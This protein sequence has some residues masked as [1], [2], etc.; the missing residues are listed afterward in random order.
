MVSFNL[1]DATLA[2]QRQIKRID[3]L[4]PSVV[5][6]VD[7][8]RAELNEWHSML[9]PFQK[10][11]IATYHDPEDPSTSDSKPKKMVSFASQ[12]TINIIPKEDPY[13]DDAS[14]ADSMDPVQFFFDG[15][16]AKPLEQMR[17]VD[18]SASIEK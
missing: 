16:E 18:L 8:Y 9:K 13:P 2:Q 7:A 5:Q 12:I 6:K 17:P 10:S 15:R 1:S 11:T 4:K 14:D 3:S